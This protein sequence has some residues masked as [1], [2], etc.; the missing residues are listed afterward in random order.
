MRDPRSIAATFRAFIGPVSLKLGDGRAEAGQ[1]RFGFPG[2]HRPGLIEA[3]CRTNNGKKVP[4]F[5]AF[6]GPV[7]LKRSVRSLARGTRN[8]FRA[9]IGPVS[10]KPAW[11]L[12]EPEKPHPFRAF[13]GPVSLKQ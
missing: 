7:S 9:F 10:L 12:R 8:P 5:R 2:L 1:F 3:I 4:A 13:I 6:I 11:T